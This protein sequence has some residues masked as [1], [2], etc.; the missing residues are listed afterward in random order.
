M[1]NAINPDSYNIDYF[2]SS[3]LGVT[4]ADDYREHLFLKNLGGA[5]APELVSSPAGSFSVPFQD[6]GDFKSINYGGIGNPGNIEEWLSEGGFPT[7]IHEVRDIGLLQAQNKYGPPTISAYNC[8]ELIP[9]DTGFI[10]YPTS[11]GGDDYK[12]ILINDAIDSNVGLGPGATINFPSELNDIAKERRKEEA[13]NRVKLNVEDNVLGKLNLDPFGLLAGQDLILRD[14]KI[15]TRRNIVGKIFDTVADSAGFNIPTSPIKKGAFGRYGD[16]D[17]AET[18][19]D[20][21]KATG[22]GTKSLLFDSVGKNKYGPQLQEP[23]GFI[24]NTVGAGQAPQQNTYLTDPTEQIQEEKKAKRNKPLVDKVNQAIGKAIDAVAGSQAIGKED[25]Q[26]P[27]EFKNPTVEPEL[28]S[29]DYGFD[30]LPNRSKDTWELAG[31]TTEFDIDEGSIGTRAPF[32]QQTDLGFFSLKQEM[33]WGSTPKGS[34]NP[35]KRGIL[36]YTQDL[37]NNTNDNTDIISKARFIGVVNDDSNFDSK[38]RKHKNYSMGNTVSSDGTY[39]RSWS[40]RNPYL[41]VGDLIRHGA[42][43]GAGGFNSLTR[44]DRDLSV[45]GNNGFVKVAPYVG[46]KQGG[47]DSGGKVLNLGDPTIQKYMLSIENLAWQNTEHI[48]KVPPCEVGPNGGRIMWFPPYD[49][50]FTDNSSVSWDT[51]NFIGRGEPIYT[52]NN[53]E[54][55][56]TLAFKLV[57]DHPLAISELREQGE[58]ALFQ[59]FAGCKNPLEEASALISVS[60][61]E[62]VKIQNTQTKLFPNPKYQEIQTQPAGDPPSPVSFYFRNARKGAKDTVGT[63]PDTEI[64]A[65][66][67]Y[68]DPPTVLPYIEEQTPQGPIG[69]YNPAFSGDVAANYEQNLDDARNKLAVERITDEIIP[70]LLSPRGKRFTINVVGKTSDAN[71]SSFNEKLGEARAKNTEEWFYQL[72]KGSELG[73]D[74]IKAENLGSEETYPTETTWKGSKLRWN[75]YSTGEK[76]SSDSVIINEDGS[77]SIGRDDNKV[78]GDT[79]YNDPGAV[80]DRRVD[81]TFTHNPEI[82]DSMIGPASG[83][84]EFISVTTTSEIIQQREIDAERKKELEQIEQAKVLARKASQYMAWECSYFEK[85]KQ[86]DPFVY[87]TLT[88]K[89]KYFHPA[90]HSM[91]PEGFNSRL[92]FLKQCTRQGPNIASNEPNNLAFGKPPICVLRVGDFYHTKIVIDTVNLTFDP[93]I[94][95]LNPE[96]IGV[97]PMVCSVDLNFKFIGGSSLGGPIAQLQNAVGFNFFANTG[98]YNPRTIYESVGEYKAK[99]VDPSTGKE[100]ETKIDTPNESKQ[101]FGYGAFIV[102]GESIQDGEFS[103]EDP[104]N[105]FYE[106]KQIQAEADRAKKAKMAQAEKDRIEKLE[107]KE[108]REKAKESAQ[109]LLDS[110][111]ELVEDILTVQSF[112]KEKNRLKA[113][114]ELACESCNIPSTTPIKLKFITSLSDV[115]NNAV[116]GDNKAEIKFVDKALTKLYHFPSDPTEGNQ[117]VTTKDV[118]GAGGNSP[119]YKTTIEGIRLDVS[120]RTGNWSTMAKD[121]TVQL[122]FYYEISVT[123][124]YGE[125]H[126]LDGGGL[127]LFFTLNPST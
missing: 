55:M 72:L 112:K 115:W 107:E 76:G 51:T 54:R 65:G 60:D 69:V 118:Y 109:T 45:L 122:I 81:I 34:T 105:D 24:A 95:D 123:D 125:K 2:P 46:E 35:F 4:T 32:G 74:P 121:T 56:G 127:P 25:D 111:D 106:Q 98:L 48:L 79:D 28:N 100:T 75:V 26:P 97:Q 50:N 108:A 27:S 66:Y 91:T 116:N 22:S 53:T 80:N 58:Q 13:I 37:I 39:C 31:P 20:L 110:L 77:T 19:K 11:S 44:P 117:I 92:T 62:E 113:V 57:I 82:D 7:T 14:Y 87:D 90:F 29:E 93:L 38:T 78:Y 71:T 102:P 21:L 33:F 88:Q 99:E 5:I 67:L 9:E 68:G 6:R 126:T 70:F 124:I 1:P 61:I 18:Y 36:K 114:S 23:K 40:V 83:E 3:L 16:L 64:N 10:Q 103:T 84:K 104:V 17:N 94:W 12:T 41:K 63:Q 119:G 120:P 85:M 49:I 52:Y 15:T 73:T 30:G 47:Y 59:F 86:D 96:G 8:P 101:P 89:L 43:D 42:S